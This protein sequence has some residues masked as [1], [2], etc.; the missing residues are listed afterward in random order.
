MT[1]CDDP[2]YYNT[3][4]PPHTNREN[5]FHQETFIERSGDFLANSLILPK[6]ERS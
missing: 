2:I 1:E 5:L 4:S 3:M 6:L